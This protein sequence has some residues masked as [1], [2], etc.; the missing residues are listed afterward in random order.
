[1][2]LGC[3]SVRSGG[4]QLSPLSLD[5]A[6]GLGHVVEAGHL[7]LLCKPHDRQARDQVTFINLD[8]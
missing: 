5:A 1:V 2:T 3:R 4:L 7:T 8:G 6:A